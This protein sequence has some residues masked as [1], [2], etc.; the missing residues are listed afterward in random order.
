MASQPEIANY[1]AGVYQLEIVDP[2]QGGVGG[3]SNVPLLNLANRTKWLYT[4]LGLVTSGTLIPPTVAPL[5][6]PPITGTP[7]V[8][9]APLGDSSQTIANTAFVQGTVNGMTSLSV[10]G[11]VNVTLTAVQAGA[12]ILQFTGALTGNIAVI[13]PGASR[14]WI[15]QNQTTGAFSLTVKTASGVGTVVTQG[16]SQ[17]LV[18]DGNNVWSGFTDF[19]NVPLT[20]APTAPT[21]AQFDSST[22]LSTTAFVQRALGNFQTGSQI[23]A[24]TTLTAA[25]SGTA[26]QIAGAYTVTLPLYSTM[27]TGAAFY[28]S[29]NTGSVAT[30]QRNTG[31]D[32]TIT[33][34]STNAG[35]VS[36]GSGDTLLLI[37]VGGIWLA[38][39]GS[40]A[41]ANA[42][43]ITSK[44]A[45]LVSPALTGNPTAPTQA[46]FDS[47][48]KLSTTAFV[49]RALGSRSGLTATTT[50][51]LTLALSAIGQTIQ[52]YGGSAATWT[53]PSSASVAAGGEYEIVNGSG[54]V[55]TI[56]A[57]GTDSIV[58]SS[59]IGI[60][61]IALQPGDSIR[62]VG[63]GGNLFYAAGGSATLQWSQSLGVTPAVA[64]NSS[65]LATTAF[66][67][68]ALGAFAGY[69]AYNANTTLTNALAN[70]AIQS[71]GGTITYTLPVGSTMPSGSTL[72]FYNNGV[73]PLSIT[74]QGSDFIYDGAN[75]QPVVLQIGDN[76]ELMS[77]GGTEWD[78]VG[79][80]AALQYVTGPR[81][82]S[83]AQFDS[84][85]KIAT[86]AFVQQAQG[87]FSAYNLITNTA[88]INGSQ[89][90]GF[91][92]LGGT[93]AYNV[94]LPAPTQSNLRLTFYNSGSSAVTLSTPSGLIFNAL[95]NVS[96]LS[97]PIG[98]SIELVSTGGN[99]I[100]IS[101]TGGA[102]LAT[103]G[104]QKLPSGLIIQW[105]QVPSNSS[106]VATLTLPIAF[107]NAYLIG[108][109]N[110]LQN[111]AGLQSVTATISTNSSNTQA[112]ATASLNNVAVSSATVFF[113]VIGR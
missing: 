42:A 16:K 12:G 10:A 81:V 17:L 75:V 21:Q 60:A 63:G 30:V 68:R 94:T 41:D 64:D 105:G 26:Y 73:G 48:T 98:G 90:G 44:F 86:T 58:R 33:T 47:S 25:N 92:N 55:L 79:G 52:Y 46:Q 89:T 28:F 1:D 69:V 4:Q 59:G 80:T 100:A 38:F 85:T 3:V 67:Q 15:V 24:N 65:K 106:G 39:S 31:T 23:N 83:P 22:K 2:V 37:A 113:I 9:T 104:Y 6:S 87:N 84:S 74:T 76:L 45:P 72:T 57:N 93:T 61:S 11:G 8:P 91:F 18:C 110:Y 112:I 32:P 50:A 99:W 40:V 14:R 82:A 20:G 77:R 13:V 70:F 95:S 97:V 19:Q 108:V 78:I 62:L 5:N 66:V 96:T 29:N 51:T 111:A 103:N 27:S 88:T 107:P 7:T 36:I 102:S 71:F 34:G 49:Q 101:G 56:N 53:L 35:S 54:Y 43:A 109:A